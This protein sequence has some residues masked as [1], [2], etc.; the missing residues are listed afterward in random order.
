MVSE[1]IMKQEYFSICLIAKYIRWV[2][3]SKKFKNRQIFGKIYCFA[4]P[5]RPH[6][7]R[8]LLRLLGTPLHITLKGCRVGRLARLKKKTG[9]LRNFYRTS[10]TVVMEWQNAIRLVSGRGEHNG[11]WTLKWFHDS[12]R[13]S[14]L[15]Q[16]QSRFCSLYS[17]LPRIE[18]SK[19]VYNIYSECPS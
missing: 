17:L 13:L 7:G 5:R 6:D 16:F 15:Q 9:V 18:V 2:W 14:L 11:R 12:D 8:P 3:W 4:E 10:T 1:L 19:L